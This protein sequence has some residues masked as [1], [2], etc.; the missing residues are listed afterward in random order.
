VFA[1]F[2]SLIFNHAFV[3]LVLVRFVDLK[4]Y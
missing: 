1:S 2:Y 3:W 4:I